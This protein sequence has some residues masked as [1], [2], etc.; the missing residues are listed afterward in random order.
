MKRGC[1]SFYIYIR[2]H[3]LSSSNHHSG[4]KL[5]YIRNFEVLKCI[6]DGHFGKAEEFGYH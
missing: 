5:Q 6:D 1:P 4:D 2:V 3:K